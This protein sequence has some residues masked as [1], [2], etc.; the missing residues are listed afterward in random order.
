MKT[1]NNLYKKLC[2]LENLNI[3]WQKARKGKTKKFYVIE[4]EKNLE[5][6]L[7]KLQFELENKIY[8]PQPLKKFIIRD[9]KTRKIYS[10][11]F[12]D[13][14]IHH[15]IVNILE[16]IF[17]PIFIFDSYASR[18][19]KGHHKALKRFDYF[20]RKVSLNGKKLKGIKDK[21]Y[22]CGY[23]LKADIK[24]YFES[25]NHKILISIIEKIINDRDLI[26][27]INKILANYESEAKGKGMPLGNLTSQFFANV[28]LNKLD[29]F[30][31]H[32][33]R[34]KYYIRYV[35]DFIILHNNKAVLENY[36]EKINHYLK[37]LKL[38]LHPTKSRVIPLHKGTNFLGFRVFFHHKLLSKKNIKQIN[39]KLAEW[40]KEAASTER[41][42]NNPCF[43]AF[44]KDFNFQVECIKELVF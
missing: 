19:N 41:T 16:P 18:K 10:S 14:I 1:Y 8:F 9:P 2:S 34:T 7:K 42:L 20:K 32:K 25:V 36:K 39:K 23:V 4:F 40:K 17:E 3:A 30:V 29:Y 21:N 12:R 35:D 15:A 11:V 22:I 13:R 38:E 33:L 26:S 37:N 44:F 24:N 6:N 28:Y 27:L 5:E 31:K 43:F